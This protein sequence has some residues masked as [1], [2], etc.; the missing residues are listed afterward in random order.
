MSADGTK[1]YNIRWDTGVCYQYTLSTPWNISTASSTSNSTLSGGTYRNQL[2]LKDDGTSMYVATEDNRV[3]QF[4]LSTPWDI[5]TQSTSGTKLV[6]AQESDLRGVCFSYDG[7]KMYII[8]RAQDTIFQYTCSTP[9]SASSASYDSVSV[10]TTATRPLSITRSID[11]T[12]FYVVD[13]NTL[14]QYDLSTAWDMSTAVV[15]PV[16]YYLSSQDTGSKDI[17][18]KPDGSKMVLNG[19]TNKKFFQYNTGEAWAG[20]GY[21]TVI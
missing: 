12:K 13:V 3:R 1:A 17:A 14:I 2:F 18:W 5:T 10:T 6:S 4:N 19:Y 21:A 7:T 11:G 16:T 15:N 9:W 20:T 8:G